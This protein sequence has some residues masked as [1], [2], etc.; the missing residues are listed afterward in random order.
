MLFLQFCRF[1][2][3]AFWALFPLQLTHFSS[4][5]NNTI[6]KAEVREWCKVLTKSRS[7]HF[8][9]LLVMSFSQANAHFRLNII[10]ADPSA[11]LANNTV[12]KVNQDIDVLFFF[13][14][15]PF[16]P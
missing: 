15:K 3:F 10:L 6:I 14:R 8:V 11:K 4:L 16:N 5:A 2:N 9:I 12:I 13:M 1:A 7:E